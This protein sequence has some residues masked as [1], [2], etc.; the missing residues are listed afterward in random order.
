MLVLAP[1]LSCVLFR[2]FLSLVELVRLIEGVGVR[3]GEV[4]NVEEAGV[5]KIGEDG[6]AGDVG[7]VDDDDDDDDDT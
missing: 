5:G 4:L 6:E 2:A 7:V 3:L 1:I